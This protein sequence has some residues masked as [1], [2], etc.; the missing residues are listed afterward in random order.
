[1]WLLSCEKKHI[2]TW[3]DF[4]KKVRSKGCKLL[5]RL[6][7]FPNSILVTGCQ[8][9]GTTMLSRV[10]TLSEGM[11]NYWF[12]KDDELDAA[13]ILSGR[14]PHKPKG[15][16]CFQTTYLNDCYREY[17]QHLNNDHKLI[18]VLRNPFSVV[19][20][21]LRN[22]RRFALNNLFKACGADLLNEGDKKRYERFGIW[23]IS[24]LRRACFSYV[25]KTSQ[26]FELYKRLDNKRLLIV[27]YDDLVVEKH[28]ILPAIYEFI[29]LE[30]KKEYAAKIHQE[31]INK[32]N[33][34]SERE[35]Y[36]IKKLC[37]P[38]Y[39]KARTLLSHL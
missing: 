26:L 9:S 8:R 37:W 6:D 31:S 36:T 38:T 28:R 21:F 22:W 34:L 29:E 16:Y 11:T 20:S 3:Q 14:V 25:G 5:A 10:I 23:T 32:A 18:W 15:R 13:L 7:E 2:T 30:Y 17:F 4:A 24:R 1:M 27:D 33:R 39:E 19:Y 12:G 35:R